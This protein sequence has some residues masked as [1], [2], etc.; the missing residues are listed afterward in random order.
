[1]EPIYL[2]YNATT[3][4]ARE[5]AEVMQPYLFEFFGNPSSSHPFGSKTKKAIEEARQQVASLINTQPGEIIFTSGGT[6][7]NNYAIRGY[8][9]AHRA[10][11]NHI[12]TSAIEHPAVMEVCRALTEDGF[13]LTILPVDHEGLVSPQDLEKTIRSETILVSIML[14]NN[15]VGSIQPVRELA[16]ITHRHGAA[17]HTDAAQAVG[18][19]VVDI[20]QLGVDLLSIAGHKFYAPKGVGALYCKAGIQLSKLMYGAN[21]E[22]NRRPGTENVLEIVGLGK[23][24]QIAGRDLDKNTTH[25]LSMRD[26][27]HQSLVRSLGETQV[28]LNGSKQKRLPNTLSLSFRAI[29]ANT[30]LA[31]IS[32]QVAASAGAA[33]HADQVDVSAVL[34]AMKVPL[35]WAMGTV[36]FSVGRETTEEMINNATSIISNAVRRLQ[37]NAVVAEPVLFLDG[38]SVKLTH[39][40]HGMGCACKLR[41]QILEDVIRKLPIP[42]DP[43]VLV[44]F[45]TADDATVYQVRDDL[46][47]V[48]TVDFFTPIVDD[49]YWFGAI[50]A[51]NS[52]SDI[53]AMGGVPLFGLNVVGFPSN[54]LPQQVLERILLGAMEKA[55]E[56]GVSVLGGHTVEDNEPKYGMAVTGVIH[57]EKVVR[58]STAR[59]GDVLVLTKPLGFG[60]LSTALKRGLLENDEAEEAIRW[61]AALNK[62]ASEVMMAVGVNACT[63]VTGFGLLGHLMEMSSSSKVDVEIYHH[64]IPV[65]PSALRLAQADVIPGGSRDN[66]TYVATWVEFDPV[67]ANYQKLILADAQT[68]GGLL[69]SVPENKVVELLNGLNGNANVLAAV[70]GKFTKTGRGM[71]NVQA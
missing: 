10:L 35:E 27:L 22:A 45:E 31:E 24:S 68:S 41:P 55:K 2:D 29:E 3:P 56:A 71:I 44:G 20:R 23:A 33:C 11:G 1:M 15:E 63:D 51:A 37:P 14:A 70:I 38:D 32:D 66:L 36:R 21:H 16:E 59:E 30:L 34:Q 25:F 49:P 42:V 52:I 13:Q 18:K 43:K 17:F 8:C 61:M 54:R 28:R 62:K 48:Q 4:I 40:T 46:A 19:I 6:E 65:L 50:S 39:F 9:L 60:I 67:I 26:L 69:I 5:V 58:N 64:A 12:I 47:L 53:Y 57:P 7:A